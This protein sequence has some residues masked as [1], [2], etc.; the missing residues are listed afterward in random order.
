MVS[1]NIIVNELEQTETLITSFEVDPA[2]P[3]ERV[4]G[5][6]RVSSE[7]QGSGD[8]PERQLEAIELHC[9]RFNYALVKVFEDH[10]TGTTENRP[11]WIK[12]TLALENNDD[13][14]KKVVIE[15]LDRLARDIM[16]SEHI[17]KALQSKGCKLE[18]LYE[19][20]DL[21]ANDPTR[22]LI[23]II[24]GAI[25]EYDKAMISM[26]MKAGLERKRATLIKETGNPK[27]KVEGRLNYS[28]KHPELIESI[29][30]VVA[31]NP[32]A[33]HTALADE[34]NRR[35]IKPVK[36]CS[37]RRSKMPVGY[38][39]PTEFNRNMVKNILKHL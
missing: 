9:E 39:E 16:V 7:G 19:G 10:F 33:S 25:A 23:R 5:Y 29:R 27:P 37:P 26:R 31:E 21:A 6:I 32:K 28:Q 3:R 20:V 11:D 2:D 30:L 1:D 34:L 12:L 24:F 35:G 38:W 4:Y 18:S 8:G 13:G 17:V 22:K 14:V 36:M 15:K